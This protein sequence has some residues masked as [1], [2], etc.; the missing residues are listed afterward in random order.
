MQG[1]VQI[2]LFASAVTA[3]NIPLQ[4][5]ARTSIL[6]GV[7]R[8]LLI[9]SS[10]RNGGGGRADARQNIDFNEGFGGGGGIPG[11]GGFG[12][13]GDVEACI[14]MTKYFLLIANLLY[15]NL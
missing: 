4:D 2:V 1:F 10:G 8:G 9:N 11:L 12:L 6:R 3:A 7:L 13:G 14:G 15:S 5:T